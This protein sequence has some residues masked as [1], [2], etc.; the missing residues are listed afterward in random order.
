[1]GWK[2]V[3]SHKPVDKVEFTKHP[4]H[5]DAYYNDS[6]L[7]ASTGEHRRLRRVFAS[8]FT[9][10]AIRAE[11][12]IMQKHVALFLQR[13]SEL[14][15]SDSPID[16]NEWIN[17]TTFDITGEL[18]FGEPFHCL[19]RSALHAWIGFIFDS[20]RAVTMTRLLREYTWLRLF[21]P[22][23]VSK[24]VEAQ[25]RRHGELTAAWVAKRLEI[26]PDSKQD[27]MRH[28]AQHMVSGDLT[29]DQVRVD[30]GVFVTAGSET[31]AAT[32]A[33]LLYLICKHPD[34]YAELAR[35]IR[36][37]FVSEAEIT[38]TATARLAYLNMCIKETMRLHPPAPELAGRRSP[39]DFVGG[40]WV[41][42]GVRQ[43]PLLFSLAVP[44]LRSVPLY[45]GPAR[46]LLHSLT[47]TIH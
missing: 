7:N 15:A 5:Y 35:E 24:E 38:I 25:A 3:F 17:Y 47:P 10:R 22:L 23:L 12:P 29:R 34:V 14:S 31:S 40:Y 19:E 16:L 8:A 27:F 28:F 11:E 1:M 39:G 4:R 43:L 2:E 13:L 33:A 18:T 26:P 45:A 46:A 30:A 21:L 41:S 44:L 9:E 37:A 32:T 6:L 42:E 20:L 36:G